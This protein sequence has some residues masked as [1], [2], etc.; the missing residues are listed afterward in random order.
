M[1]QPP[2]PVPLTPP[3]V[4][5]RTCCITVVPLQPDCRELMK[6]FM[7]STSSAELTCLPG[8]NETP[9]AGGVVTWFMTPRRR[10]LQLGLPAIWVIDGLLQYQSFMVTTSFDTQI[11]GH[12]PPTTSTSSDHK[13]PPRSAKRH[14]SKQT[15]KDMIMSR[16]QPVPSGTP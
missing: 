9:G 16:S 13:T 6:V 2:L 1:L 14:K 3:Y 5:K 8:T 12:L 10:W 15:V 4:I 11:L 7:D